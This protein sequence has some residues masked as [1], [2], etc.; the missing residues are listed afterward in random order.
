VFCLKT[1]TFA[2]HAEKGVSSVVGPNVG[3]DT[4]M[5]L[6]LVRVSTSYDRKACNCKSGGVDILSLLLECFV[7]HDA[8]EVQL[9]PRQIMKL[10]M[11]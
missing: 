11:T 1:A 2:L 3:P 8:R 10:G 5:L 4:L 9:D 7:C 6:R